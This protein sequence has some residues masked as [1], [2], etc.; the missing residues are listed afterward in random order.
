MSLTQSPRRKRSPERSTSTSPTRSMSMIGASTAAADTSKVKKNPKGG[1]LVTPEEIRAAFSILDIEKTGQISIQNLKKRL[2]LFFPDMT[3]KEYRFLMNNRKEITYEDLEE[4]LMDNDI[5]NYDPALDAFRA[6]DP[7]NTG[8]VNAEKL[9]EIFSGCQFG[10]LSDEE[11]D[12][13]TRVSRWCGCV[14]VYG[15]ERERL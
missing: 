15:R 12:I 7:A 6:F 3:A 9:R 4:L 8:G 5:T 1:I 13:L 2:S 10:E 14:C 11:L